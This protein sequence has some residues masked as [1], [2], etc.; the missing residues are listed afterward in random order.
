[1]KEKGE[2]MHYVRNEYLIRRVSTLSLGVVICL[3]LLMMGNVLYPDAQR[4]NVPEEEL[5]EVRRAAEGGLPSFLK[6]I[7]IEDLEEYGLSDQRELNQAMVGNP[8]RI[9]TVAPESILD[10]SREMSLEE[11]ISPTSVWL[12]P[13]IV[14]AETRAL[15]TVDVMGGEW[16]AVAIGRSGLAKQWASVVEFWPSSEGYEHT[17]VRVFQAKSDFVVLS[18]PEKTEVTP[19]ESACVSLGLSEAET[20]SLSEVMMK[21]Q[22]PVQDNLESSQFIDQER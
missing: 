14:K 19:L 4:I 9:Y 8:F 10:Y 2:I 13:V 7:P 11:I 17:F 3:M 20:Y 6:T 1:M 16:R 21:L 15:L 18:H 22:K 5:E 12:F